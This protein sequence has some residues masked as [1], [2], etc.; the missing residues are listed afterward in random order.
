MEEEWRRNGF[1]FANG[2]SMCIEEDVYKDMVSNLRIN[3]LTR[4]WNNARM[5]VFDEFE[6]QFQACD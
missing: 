6:Q 5:L 2:E 1:P 3:L 4:Q